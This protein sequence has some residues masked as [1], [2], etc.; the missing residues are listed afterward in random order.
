M[1]LLSNAFK[2]TRHNEKATIEIC[3]GRGVAEAYNGHRHGRV[4]EEVKPE[5]YRRCTWA[6]IVWK[7]S[8]YGL[9]FLTHV[10]PFSARHSVTLPETRG[11][12]CVPRPAVASH[13]VAR[14]RLHLIRS[15]P[16]GIRS[17]CP[18]SQK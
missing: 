6:R 10:P 17:R 15:S 9:R 3:V 7:I 18:P 8:A 12:V 1:N 14:Q 2:L 11:R 16:L 4:K 13:A 5:P